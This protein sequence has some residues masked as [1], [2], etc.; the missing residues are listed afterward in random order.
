MSLSQ[1]MASTVATLDTRTLIR[2]IRDSETGGLE[3][4]KNEHYFHGLVPKAQTAKL[5]KKK[6]DYLVRQALQSECS[7]RRSDDSFEQFIISVRTEKNTTKLVRTEEISEICKDPSKVES[8]TC[9][10]HILVKYSRR[11]RLYYVKDFGFK[12]VSGLIDYHQRK[13][14]PLDEEGTLLKYPVKR[15]KW[16]LNHEQVK[17]DKLIGSGA[18]GEV[19]SGELR[20]GI[21]RKRQVAIKII[22]GSMT[23]AD[24]EGFFEE[25]MLMHEFV[26]PNVVR[27]HGVALNE[28]PVM[29]VMELAEENSVLDA[30]SASRIRRDKKGKPLT[31]LP[32]N[33]K[34]LNVRGPADPSVQIRT[35][36]CLGAARGLAYIASK[37]VIHRDI[38]ARNV[39][40]GRGYVAKISDF[41]LGV[42]AK[43]RREKRLNKV[44]VRY[45]SPE[46]LKNGSYTSKTDI[47]SFGVFLWEVFHDGLEPYYSIDTSAE[48][49]KYVKQGNTL[50][51]SS[52][53]YPESLWLLTTKCFQ[54]NP[55]DRP[56]A[57]ACVDVISQEYSKYKWKLSKND[58]TFIRSKFTKK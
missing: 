38:A 50:P 26:H 39:L 28:N 19:W 40:I 32:D 58:L 17:K 21:L 14:H 20:L 15:A 49:V 36:L 57:S 44:P 25:A 3:S 6:G 23:V 45:L 42:M 4:V 55:D 34:L 35:K 11:E 51:N 47:W 22:I 1:T 48:I 54:F 29:I 24:H 16:Q 7:R 43:E 5:L 31:A 10:R 37:N 56:T 53:F 33:P 41:G 2:K 46:T 27:L 52:E 30:V 9:V 13:K 12:H 18:F 8:D